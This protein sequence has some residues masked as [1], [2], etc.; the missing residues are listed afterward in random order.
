MVAA[1]GAET[2]A[3]GAVC[4]FFEHN[5]SDAARAFPIVPGPGRRSHLHA[6]DLICGHTPHRLGQVLG[7]HCLVVHQHLK[8]GRPAQVHVAHTVH[9]Q[10][11]SFAQNVGDR[12]A[13]VTQV[14]VGVVG[15]ALGCNS[16]LR[17][18]VVT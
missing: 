8:I 6:L 18:G 4:I 17:A 13:G 10:Q 12:Y 15:V 9:G 11:G 3:D 14:V 7:R 1:A 16:K 2:A 5:V